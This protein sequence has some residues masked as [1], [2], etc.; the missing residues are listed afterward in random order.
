MRSVPSYTVPADEVNTSFLTP[1][2]TQ[3]STTV[4]VP[5]TLTF[6]HTSLPEPV[7][8]D[9]VWKTVVAPAQRIAVASES[10][11]VRSAE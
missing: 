11:E 9:A 4:C 3:A 1:S 5:C 2:C 6:S 10:S 7:H 8:G